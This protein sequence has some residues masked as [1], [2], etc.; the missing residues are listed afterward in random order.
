MS[1]VGSFSSEFLR[2]V[3]SYKAEPHWESCQ[4]T[5]VA[6]FREYSRRTRHIDYFRKKGSI[7]DEFQTKLQLVFRVYCYKVVGL[8]QGILSVCGQVVTKFLPMKF[9][10]RSSFILRLIVRYRVAAGDIT[11]IMHHWYYYGCIVS[12]WQLMSFWVGIIEG[13]LRK[14]FVRKN[15]FQ[16]NGV[17]WYV[18]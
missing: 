16:R 8:K 7:T 18:I 10:I 9:L 17:L 12:D 3:I 13:N 6:L 2:A 14:V 4:T 5:R 15:V 11:I 1:V